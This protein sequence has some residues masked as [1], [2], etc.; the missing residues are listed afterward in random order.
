MSDDSA[1]NTGPTLL[2][3]RPRLRYFLPPL[4]PR[5]PGRYVAMSQ[6][7]RFLAR[8][9]ECGSRGEKLVRAECV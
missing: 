4:S 2:Y 5:G 3:A 8:V 9:F 7:S 6:A 1:R